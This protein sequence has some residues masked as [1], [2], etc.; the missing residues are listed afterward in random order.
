MKERTCTLFG[1]DGEELE[2]LDSS[3]EHLL[4]RPKML[5]KNSN[6][7]S[8]QRLDKSGSRLLSDMKR[9]RTSM[10]SRDTEESISQ[11]TIKENR[12]SL[13]MRLK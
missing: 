12:N 6:L 3:R 4:R 13:S 2:A 7:S 1:P 5:S 11:R 10:T 9:K 8:G